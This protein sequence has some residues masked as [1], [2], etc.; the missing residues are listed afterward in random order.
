ML[1]GD[2]FVPLAVFLALLMGSAALRR[3]RDTVA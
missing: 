3:M 1:L 2:P